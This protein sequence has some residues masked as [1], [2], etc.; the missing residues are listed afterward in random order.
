MGDGCVCA[1]VRAYICAYLCMYVYIHAVH[2]RIY[3][4]VRA[5]TA[6]VLG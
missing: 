6:V 4:Y 2:G 1:C 5:R 3:I